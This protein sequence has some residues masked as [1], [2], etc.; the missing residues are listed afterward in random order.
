MS[1]VKKLI[2]KLVGPAAPFILEWLSAVKSFNLHAKNSFSERNPDRDLEQLRYYL[3]KRC[4]IVEKGMALP[5]PREAFGQPKIKDLI[6]R[7]ITFESSGGQGVGQIVRDTLRQYRELYRGKEELF[8]PGFIKQMDSFISAAP[9]ESKGGL[10]K[11]KKSQWNDLSLEKFDHFVSFRHSVRNFAQAPVDQ[12][13]LKSVIATSLKAPSVCNR[14]GWFIHYYDNKDTMAELLYYQNGNA[15]F[16]E[17]IDKL[18]IVTGNLKAFTRHEH[19]QLFVDG[20][21]VSMNLML[22]IHAAGLGSCPLN[23]CMPYPKEK[24]L[25]AAA[26]I[27]ETERLIM[28]IA[29]GNLKEEFSVARSE[30][31]NLDSVL[32]HH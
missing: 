15:G 14:Q 10:K 26:Q 21:L 27:P 25:M 5:S 20:G 19:N 32:V 9:S 8:E 13:L 16:T 11:L 6:A 7:T 17:S 4:H 24:K 18:L 22:S 29:V 30:K 2:K 28:M 23:T 12:E 1:I 3:I 31:Y